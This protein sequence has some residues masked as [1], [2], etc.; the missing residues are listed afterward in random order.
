MSN[1]E[2]LTKVTIKFASLRTRII[3]VTLILLLFSASA[4]AQKRE[5]IELLPGAE[6]IVGGTFN[7]V[8]INIIRGG[9]VILKQG[10]TL[11]YCD[12]A[13]KYVDRNA[14]EA[15]GR[16]TIMQGDTVSLTGDTLSYD[17]DIKL[18]KMRGQVAMR[19]RSMTMNTRK[20][21]YDISNKLAYYFDG[22]QVLDA[23]NNLTSELGFYEVKTKKVYFKNK[24][25][26]VNPDFTLYSDTLQYNTATKIA[27]IKGPTDIETKDGWKLFATDGDY[28]TNKKISQ[29]RGA[30][31]IEDEKYL[32]QGD[33]LYYDEKNDYGLAKRNVRLTSK[34]DNIILEGDIGK[35][36]GKK[37]SSLV[38]GKA[39]MR[40]FLDKDTLYAAADTFLS[41]GNPK[42]KDTLSKR[43]YAFRN[44]K[45]YKSDLQG[46]CDSLRYFFADSTL[47]MLKNPIIW[48]E[49][50]QLT[51]DS[52]R[53]QLANSKVSR[54][55]MRAN[56]FSLSKDSL[57]NYNQIKGRDMTAFIEAD[58]LQRVTVE[59]NAESIYFALEGDT[60][61]VG[62]DKRLSSDMLIR[63]SNKRA[64]QIISLS[65]IEGTFLPADKLSESEGKL[66]GFN[67]RFDERPDKLFFTRR[68]Y[69]P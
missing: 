62:M 28:D 21:D 59:G 10:N 38:Y 20:L 61:V 15:F 5:K 26:L 40:R 29:F 36:W 8:R 45:I 53:I 44:V 68:R 69:Y 4:L 50:S 64:K 24:V 14:F 67:P 37:D 35:Y 17:G 41:I 23:R 6:E 39:L 66:E 48:N 46:K 63:F 52:V 47:H 57:N 34:K 19:H 11:M 33:S 65:N 55:Y 2:F 16:I 7:G 58:T 1:F 54:I 43:I 30:A 3:Y 32:L 18:A 56:S 12:S 22:G 27:Y 60:A 49:G 13:Y 9:L 42:T 31:R 25:L 51:A